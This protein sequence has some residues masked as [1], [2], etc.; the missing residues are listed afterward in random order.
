MQE[1]TGAA[2]FVEKFKSVAP[3]VMDPPKFPS[4]FAKGKPKEVDP[5]AP[6]PSKVSFNFYVPHE[7][8]HQ[9]AEVDL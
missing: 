6:T 9:G 5:S 4:E 1:K 3:S 7:I 8:L 2:A